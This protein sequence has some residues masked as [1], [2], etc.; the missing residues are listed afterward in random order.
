MNLRKLIIVLLVALALTAAGIQYSLFALEKVPHVLAPLSTLLGFLIALFHASQRMGWG[1]AAGMLAAT[2]SVSLTFESLGVATGAI[3]GPYHYSDKLGFLFLGLVP[4]IIPAAWF[5]MTY[6]SF[7]IADWII[8][9][10][11]AWRR[12]Q[13]AAI[14]AA[15]MTAWDLVMDPIMVRAG[16]WV[17]EIQGAYFGIPVHNFLG[18]WLTTFISFGVFLLLGKP[19]LPWRDD[20]QFD[21]FAVILFALIATMHISN[22]FLGG[23]GGPA[24]VGLF[25]I[26]PWLFFAWTQMKRYMK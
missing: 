9:A 1:R 4:L 22:A 8:P 7:V 15:V 19:A 16:H 2:F 6:P 11:A 14:G 5:M 23:L 26:F 3:Y 18:W 10:G 25:A 24:L 20:P 12:A 17:W 21:R 13:V